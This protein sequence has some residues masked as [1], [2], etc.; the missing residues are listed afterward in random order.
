M[1]IDVS[2]LVPRFLQI[3]EPVLDRLDRCE[4]CGDL[5]VDVYRGDEASRH[6][7][8]RL[9]PVLYLT[10]GEHLGLL[11]RGCADKARLVFDRLL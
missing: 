9:R 10:L 8:H 11:L 2:R 5:L 1:P 4:T 7:G 3:P 6:Q